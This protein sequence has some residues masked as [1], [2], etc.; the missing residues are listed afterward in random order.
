MCRFQRDNLS[1]IETAKANH[2]R[3]YDYLE[4]LLTKLPKHADDTS[5][6]FIQY[7]LPWSELVQEK[8][9][10]VKKVRYNFSMFKSMRI[11]CFSEFF[12][13]MVLM[14][15]CLLNLMYLLY[16]TKWAKSQYLL[17]F[18]GIYNAFK[19]TLY[20]RIKIIICYHGRYFCIT[21]IIKYQF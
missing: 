16:T 6:D 12:F 13:Y 19:H 14:F 15:E 11:R 7:L 3:V 4:L 10:G 1:I 17:S 21:N 5:R 9:G 2:L 18:G 20:R 8:Y